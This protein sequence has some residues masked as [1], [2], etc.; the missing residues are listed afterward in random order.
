MI[1]EILKSELKKLSFQGASG[2]IHF[3]EQQEVPS[4]VDVFQ[5]RNG[6]LVQI[7]VYN[8][9]SQKV[10]FN[11]ENYAENI[12]RDTFETF[13]ELLP[14]WLGGLMLTT[15]VILFFVVSVNMFLLILWR[16]ESAIKAS[17]PALSMFIIA[18][19]Y[20][21]CIAP[22]L[23]VILRMFVL[24]NTVLLDFLCSTRF[25]S[26]SIGLDLIFSTL[27][28]R[29]LRVHHIFKPFQ[30]ISKYW[31]DKYLFI[32][33]LLVCLGKLCLL[34]VQAAVDKIYP[35]IQREYVPTAIPPYYKATLH[36]TSGSFH[37][38]IFLSLIYSTVLLLLVLFLAIQTRH[39][40]KDNFKDTKKV[41]FFIF[42]VVVVLAITISLEVVFI[43]AGIDIGA[44]ILE[45]LAYF[46]VAMIC[47]FCLFVPKT[48]PLFVDKFIYK[49][50]NGSV[51][52]KSQ[53]T[54]TTTL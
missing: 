10:S 29:L 36:C 7:G 54:N 45:W 13:Y 41:N 48:A 12:P 9:I 38:W 34:V 44:D 35:E 23:T 15:Q 1:T 3:N 31:L 37:L 28:L 8:P 47:Q 42:L 33:I 49:R 5:F 18:G 26:E 46:A 14:S 40:H 2:W 32:H 4:F 51:K 21:L 17:S 6:T 52:K 53:S 25:W 24:E 50:N 11:M 39:V 43:E 22:I 30:Q 19:C 16:K 20:L 27:L